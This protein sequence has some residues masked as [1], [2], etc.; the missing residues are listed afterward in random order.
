V[1]A[2]PEAPLEALVKKNYD[3][4]IAKLTTADRESFDILQCSGIVGSILKSRSW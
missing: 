3:L 4:V 1:T 2:S